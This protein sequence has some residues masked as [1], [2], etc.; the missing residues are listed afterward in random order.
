MTKDEVLAKLR[1][2][3]EELREQATAEPDPA[4][5]AD[6]LRLADAREAVIED[7]AEAI[8]AEIAESEQQAAISVRVPAS[9]SVALKARAEA[10]HIPTSA[11]VRRLLTEAM[12][13]HPSSSAL[14]AEQIEQVAEIARRVYRESA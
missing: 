11:L 6:R 3:I 1:A 9:L 2:E 5:R 4:R 8:T 7:E 12:A 14:T 13:Q 10:E